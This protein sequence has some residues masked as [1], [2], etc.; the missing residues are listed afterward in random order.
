MRNYRH[1]L[2]G[3]VAV[4]GTLL[5]CRRLYRSLRR[6]IRYAP[7]LAPYYGQVPSLVMKAGNI[8]RPRSQAKAVG[9]NEIV[10]DDRRR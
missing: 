2:R 5:T 6:V 4:G 7:A 8:C 1:S 10:A 9:R 3:L